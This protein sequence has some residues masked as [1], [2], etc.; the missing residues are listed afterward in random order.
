MDSKNKFKEAINCIHDAEQLL[1]VGSESGK[2]SAIERDILLEKLRKCYE[3][4]LFQQ[5][6]ENVQPASYSNEKSIESFS[7]PIQ[8]S[9]IST[10]VAESTPEPSGS[11][12]VSDS[13][14]ELTAVNDRKQ[15]R[16]AQN[17]DLEFEGFADDSAPNVNTGKTNHIATQPTPAD[18]NV[19]EVEAGKGTTTV[20]EMYQGKKKFRN[21]MLGNG[22]K[23]IASVL[24]SKPISDLT[25]AIGINDK[26]L[27]TKELFGG[28]A[29]VYAKTIK[30]LNDFD[31]INDAII[32]IQDNFSWDD[33][34][35]AADQLI[36]LVRRKL[37]HD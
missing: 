28:N 36:E 14:E 21:E 32:F 7:A 6:N 33:G 26:F 16:T 27:F 9:E 37:L 13:P 17:N 15:E 24:K 22:K 25:K 1:K 8:H 4:V 12:V 5:I 10:K 23:D 11:N 34:N 2:L 29:E 30:K 31:N 3:L 35:E 19:E 20:A 18:I